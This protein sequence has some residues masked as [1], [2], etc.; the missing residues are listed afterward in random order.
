MD[1]KKIVR[2]IVNPTLSR[3]WSDVTGLLSLTLLYRLPWLSRIGNPLPARSDPFGTWVRGRPSGG[4][5]VTSYAALPSPGM[6]CGT[7]MSEGY[8]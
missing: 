2:K 7:V 8:A 1:V 6:L 4:Y 3:Q 5:L